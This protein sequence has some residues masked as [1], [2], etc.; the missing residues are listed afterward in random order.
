MTAKDAILRVGLLVDERFSLDNPV[1]EN[2][3]RAIYGVFS[4][5]TDRTVRR[6]GVMAIGGVGSGKSTCL[7]I[8][9]RLFRDSNCRFLYKRASEIKDLIESSPLSEIKQDIGYGLKCDLYID[10][11]GVN[12]GEIKK[13]GTT[14]SVLG[15]LLLDR[16]ELYINEGWLTH[17]SSNLLPESENPQIV[18]LKS[19]FGDRV[20]DR[21][22]EMNTQIIFTNKSLRK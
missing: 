20:Y 15:E 2:A 3:Y 18:T 21:L 4:Q 14:I 8:M 16:Y 1:I 13:Y 19:V 11:L 7:R 6:T 17:I 9:H 22:K 5:A 12:G 10:D